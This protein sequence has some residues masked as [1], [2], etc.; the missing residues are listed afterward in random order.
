[1]ET[2]TSERVPEPSRE[3]SPSLIESFL[4]TIPIDDPSFREAESAAGSIIVLDDAGDQVAVPTSRPQRANTTQLD[5]SY[6]DYE[7][8]MN[9]VAARNPSRNPSRKRKRQKNT[10]RLSLESILVRSFQTDYWY[11]LR[12]TLARIN[13]PKVFEIRV[14]RG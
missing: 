10:D 13:F 6:P 9:A 1:M 4:S 11:S 2:A 8:L 12:L 5:Y 7:Q 3:G 14:K